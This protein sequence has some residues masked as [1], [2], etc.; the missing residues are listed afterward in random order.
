MKIHNMED[1]TPA[2]TPPAVDTRGE[3]QLPQYE[4]E[5]GCF[6]KI[7]VI[8]TNSIHF[9][10]AIA[11]ITAL[12]YAIAISFHK[13]DPQHGIAVLLEIFAVLMVTAGAGAFGVM[14][15]SC[16]RITLK[17]SRWIAPFLAFSYCLLAFILLVEKS[18][19][20]RYL[21]EK[22]H[23]LFLSDRSL[24]FIMSSSSC[25][26][27]FVLAVVEGL[28]FYMLKKLKG[29]LDVY[30][31]AQRGEML[32]NHARTAAAG[33]NQWEAD[34][35]GDGR[36]RGGL[37]T[38]LLDDGEV[39]SI[40]SSQRQNSWTLNDSAASWWEEPHEN[41]TSLDMNSNN[42]SNSGGGWMSR[43]FKKSTSNDEQSHTGEEIE[44]GNL[45]SSSSAGF[46]PVD[47]EIETGITPWHDDVQNESESRNEPDLSWA[48]DEAEL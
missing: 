3:A 43:V 19:I 29:D 48:N 22:K 33:R 31:N 12:C 42:N 8:I 17:T 27:L 18:S 38:P 39:S 45:V 14:K 5:L 7:L 30:D 20:Q 36:D 2:Y 10:Q 40:S 4:T 41:Q 21:T 28:R 25:T 11:G 46:A 1:M 34:P 6:P 15:P 47:G 13:P 24:N 9:T 32:R 37:T 35:H 16:K 44:E 23:A 26:V